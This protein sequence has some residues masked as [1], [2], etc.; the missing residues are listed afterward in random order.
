[1]CALAGFVY[2]PRAYTLLFSPT[3]AYTHEGSIQ[4]D[5]RSVYA[6]AN[7]DR[8]PAASLN[9]ALSRA[10]VSGPT[11]APGVRRGSI[12]GLALHVC[13]IRPANVGT[14][15][16]KPY[17][18]VRPGPCAN[19]QPILHHMELDRHVNKVALSA[20]GDSDGRT[21]RRKCSLVACPRRSVGTRGLRDSVAA[22]L[23]RSCAPDRHHAQDAHSPAFHLPP[24]RYQ[25]VCVPWCLP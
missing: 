6:F 18:P 15:Y 25:G 13:G 23:P 10:R 22:N 19:P 16:H 5:R 12:A 9:L 1:M 3:G 21:R 7:T 20:R 17:T 11:K 8:R 4:T 2:S 24:T 14:N